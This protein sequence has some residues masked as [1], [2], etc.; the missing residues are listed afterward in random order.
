MISAHA[1]KSSIEKEIS[2]R[3][4]PSVTK[5]RKQWVCFS[6]GGDILRLE[7]H[8]FSWQSNMK[9]TIRLHTACVPK[10]NE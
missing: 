3:R 9:D 5:G 10:T 7:V 2:E 8:E 6:C 4:Y 1:E